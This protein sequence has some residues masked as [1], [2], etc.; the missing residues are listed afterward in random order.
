MYVY[1]ENDYIIS[2]KDIVSIVDY[3][4][5]IKSEDEKKYFDVYKKMIVDLSKDIKKSIVITNKY[6]Y[7]SSYTARA[8]YSRGMEYEKL[9]LKSKMEVV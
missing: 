1:L 9:K 5:F 7:I 4:K 2:M 8:L 6:I 3:E